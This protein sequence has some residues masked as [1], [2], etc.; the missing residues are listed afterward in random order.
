MGLADALQGQ[1]IFGICGFG[2]FFPHFL[3]PHPLSRSCVFV[4]LFQVVF[5]CGLF[6]WFGF[7]SPFPSFIF[8]PL[9][10]SYETLSISGCSY[11]QL[12]CVVHFHR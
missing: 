10:G 8:P 11:L 3:N 5:A 1:S 7:F 4:W 6:F 9:R 2:V 12:L